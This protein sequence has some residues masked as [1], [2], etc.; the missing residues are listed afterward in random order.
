MPLELR[1]SWC[2]IDTDV[3]NLNLGP[4]ID[5][6]GKEAISR[7]G[8]DWR[9]G[10][11]VQLRRSFEVEGDLL[12]LRDQ[13][14]LAAGLSVGIGARWYCRSNGRAGV[15]DG[16]PSPI[17]LL[18]AESIVVT[19]PAEIA[20][21]VELETCLIASWNQQGDAAADCPAGSLLWSDSWSLAPASREVLLEGSELRL[22]VE[23]ISFNDKFPSKSGALWYV[24]LDPSIEPHNLFSNVVTIFINADILK[25]DF[26]NELGEPDSSR[27]PASLIAAIRVDLYRL[28]THAL[29]SDLEEPDYWDECP[30]GAVGPALYAH[31]EEAFETVQAAL[32]CFSDEPADFSKRLWDGCAPNSWR[33]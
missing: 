29:Q 33:G 22:Q 19:L 3:E 27:I 32:A 5:D 31:L 30:D 17:P 15:H 2:L 14:K 6:Q 28:L 23:T 1:P 4:W 9:P 18:E 11:E 8:D 21:S 26:K 25:R 12:D 10:Q 7:D 20:G 16:G 24:E 13:L